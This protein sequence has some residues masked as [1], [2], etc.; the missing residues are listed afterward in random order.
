VCVFGHVQSMS[1]F[2]S[3]FGDGFFSWILNL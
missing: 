3:A 2:F 1:R